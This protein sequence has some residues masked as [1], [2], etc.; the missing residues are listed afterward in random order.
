MTKFEKEIEIATKEVR[1]TIKFFRAEHAR[2]A[3]ST[4]DA[5]MIVR[6]NERYSGAWADIP[7]EVSLSEKIVMAIAEIELARPV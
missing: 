5:M 4:P 6:G 3:C 7:T 1:N 2:G